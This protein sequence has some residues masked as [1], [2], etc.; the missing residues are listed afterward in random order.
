MIYALERLKKAYPRLAEQGV[1]EAPAMAALKISGRP[2]G[3]L[4]LLSTHPPLERRIEALK[5]YASNY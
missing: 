1:E 3:F 4:A 5:A 2:S